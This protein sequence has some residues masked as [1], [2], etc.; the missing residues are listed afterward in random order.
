[1][2]DHDTL[3][4]R[5]TRS[6]DQQA[7]GLHD[8]PFGLDDVRGRA[9]GIQRRRRAL[10]AG[11][12][13]AVVLAVAIPLGLAA[14]GRDDPRGVDPAPSP[15]LGRAT[16]LHDGELTR[17][18]GS[19]L[20]VP[21]DDVDEVATL[22][23]GRTVLMLQRRAV[24]LDATGAEQASY[25][26]AVNLLT[27]GRED[28]TVAWVGE[29]NR[30][31]V[32]EAGRPEPV[33]LAAVPESELGLS[34][35]EVVNGDECAPD[36]CRVTVGDGNAITYDVYPDEVVPTE[37]DLPF[38]SIDDVNARGD[39]WTVALPTRDG[40]QHPCVATYHAVDQA[41][42][43]Q[44]CATSGLRFSPDEQHL[45]GMRGDNSMYGELT[46]LDADLRPVLTWAPEGDL[47]ISSAAWSDDTHLDVAVVDPDTSEWSLVRV[48]LDGGS[49][50][51]EGPAPGGNPE[52][53]PDY[54]FAD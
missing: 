3:E 41:V 17:P 23:D 33:T 21:Y 32:L 49:E 10:V 34:M 12:T 26:V 22:G 19:T 45:L 35:V 24:V 15:V 31:Q 54:V 11:T 25:P 9:R 36:S 53:G 39:L 50:V 38:T 6:L 27:A 14:G 7:T 30:V 48:A 44:T 43:A 51:L 20:P 1:M 29:G 28:R 37:L 16:V 46:V 18:D 42:V 52:A 4:T 40:E 2:T 8:A 5:L 47:A 13:A